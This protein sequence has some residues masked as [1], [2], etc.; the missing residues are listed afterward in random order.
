MD[1]IERDLL[2]VREGVTVENVKVE[3]LLPGE[4]RGVVEEMAIRYQKLPIEPRLDQDTGGIIAEES[5]ISVDV[6]KTLA[7]IQAAA[8]GQ[9]VQLE[10]ITS[11]PLH[12]SQDIANAK[13]PI[14]GYQTW[15]HGS[16]ERYNN[17]SVALKS[18]N[19]T[20]VWP[21]EVFSFNEATGP[22]TPER[23][24]LPAPIILNGGYDVG[25]GGGVCQVSSTLYNAALIAKLPIIERHAHTKPVHYVPEGRD[26]TV[27][28]GYLDLKFINNR[29]GP[30]IVKTTLQNGR[31]YVELRTIKK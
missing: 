24:Y 2:G 10:I 30:L 14:A 18:I 29:D 22:R 13:H 17:I 8:P 7:Q 16:A 15:F 31:I 23:G 20:L 27:N 9:I 26:A 28:F 12:R 3:R 19:N 4:L 11:Q 1:R 5:G 25:Y 6:D 21:G